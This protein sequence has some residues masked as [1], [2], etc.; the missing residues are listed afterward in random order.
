MFFLLLVILKFLFFKWFYQ[1]HIFYEISFNINS[2][3]LKFCNIIKFN[4]FNGINK[5]YLEGRIFKKK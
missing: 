5:I 4:Y 2:I 3:I 1:S